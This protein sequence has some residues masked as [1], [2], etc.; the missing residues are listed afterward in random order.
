MSQYLYM[1]GIEDRVITMTNIGTTA[2]SFHDTSIL[3][4]R[5]VNTIGLDVTFS[6]IGAVDIEVDFGESVTVDYFIL[7]G[8]TVTDGVGIDFHYWN[9]S[10]YTVGSPNITLDDAVDGNVLFRVTERTATKFKIDISVNDDQLKLATI[11]IGQ[12]Y[13][14]PYN[15]FYGHEPGH[16]SRAEVIEDRLGYPNADIIKSG[17]HRWSGMQY[18]LRSNAEL[19]ALQSEMA[20]VS[21]FAKP[22]FFLDDNLSTTQP[23]FVKNLDKGGLTPSQ[24]ASEY[25]ILNM[26]FEE[27]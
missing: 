13:Q 23:Y 19:A 1:D 17:L 11:F 9:G 27:I 12:E 22:F 24:P 20:K 21:H 25:Y 15:Y 7:A 14:F 5:R 3:A 8:L 18:N 4:Q 16:F 6:T 2:S 10:S 26:N